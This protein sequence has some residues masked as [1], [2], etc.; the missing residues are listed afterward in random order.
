MAYLK[1]L[2]LVYLAD[3]LAL[4]KLGR[5]ITFDSYF[6]LPHGPVPS[7]TMDLASDEPDPLVASYWHR[8]IARGPTHYDVKLIDESSVPNDQLSDAEEAVLDEVFDQYGHLYRWDLVRFTH[9]LPEYRDP[10]GS[11]IPIDLADILRAQ[12]VSDDDVQDIMDAIAA[13]Q[14]LAEIT[15]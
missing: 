5:P 11:R 7:R 15:R 9:T 4:A 2:K 13:E 1:L 8:V 12:D 6:S 10:Q 14:A 3:R